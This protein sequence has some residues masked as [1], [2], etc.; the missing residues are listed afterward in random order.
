ML[1]VAGL[2][3]RGHLLQVRQNGFDH[4]HPDVL[5]HSPRPNVHH[6]HR[7]LD[8]LVRMPPDVDPAMDRQLMRETGRRLAVAT[9]KIHRYWHACGCSTSP[10]GRLRRREGTG[11]EWRVHHELFLARVS[12]TP[13]QDPARQRR[14]L[15]ILG[16]MPRAGVTTM[17]H[18]GRRNF[19]LITI[20]AGLF[21]TSVNSFGADPVTG[22]STAIAV[23]SQAAPAVRRPILAHP[24]DPSQY[25]PG[26]P[27]ATRPNRRRLYEDVM[28]TSGWFW[29]RGTPQSPVDAEKIDDRTPLVAP[30]IVSPNRLCR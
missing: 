18:R 7:S 25:Q 12:H 1:L 6:A 20:S 5:S 23:P 8:E 10:R 3:N 21:A 19:S 22:Y 29:R 2:P 27:S 28:R 26:S 17:S 16:K 9:C 4:P 11:D 30:T 15:R 24:I 14:R 13:R